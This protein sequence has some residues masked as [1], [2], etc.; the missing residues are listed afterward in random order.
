M[1]DQFPP[2]IAHYTLSFHKDDPATLKACALT[3]R[4]LM[5]LA[6][7][8]LYVCPTFLP[9][10]DNLQDLLARLACKPRLA[11]TIETLTVLGNQERKSGRKLNIRYDGSI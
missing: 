10:E 9:R 1:L 5:D 3:C 2:E 4:R 8:L 6:S 7:N 11:N